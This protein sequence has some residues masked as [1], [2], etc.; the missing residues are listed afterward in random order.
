M[1]K[2]LKLQHYL[3]KGGNESAKQKITALLRAVS[4]FTAE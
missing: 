3:F 1:Y 4:S 2:L